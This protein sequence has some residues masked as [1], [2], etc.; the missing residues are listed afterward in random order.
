MLNFKVD[1]FADLLGGLHT[2]DWREGEV[3]YKIRYFSNLRMLPGAHFRTGP[4]PFSKKIVCS[5]YY[6]TQ[7]KCGAFKS[8]KKRC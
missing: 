7:E 2:E 5:A 3:T 6:F 8:F 4:A 1:I